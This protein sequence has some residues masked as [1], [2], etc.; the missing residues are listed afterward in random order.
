MYPPQSLSGPLRYVSG[1]FRTIPDHSGPVRDQCG[2]SA[3]PVRDQC[4]TSAG[5]VRDQCGTS[6]GPVRDQCGT[7]EKR[8]K[9]TLDCHCGNTLKIFP[10]FFAI[11]A[12]NFGRHWF[13]CGCC[14]IARRQRGQGIGGNASKV[15]CGIHAKSL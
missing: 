10:D 7:S 15:V 5:P 8:L 9:S 13:A 11:L 3:G 2:T 6:A 1:P 4:G 12:T 14:G